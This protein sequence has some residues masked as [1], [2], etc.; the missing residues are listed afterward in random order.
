MITL[1]K[2]RKKRNPTVYDLRML[3]YYLGSYKLILAYKSPRKTIIPKNT[4]SL[5]LW[6]MELKRN[7][8]ERGKLLS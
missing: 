4:V 3:E 5:L 7:I 8:S 6:S 1:K 2:L